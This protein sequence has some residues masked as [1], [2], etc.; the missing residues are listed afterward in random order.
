MARKGAKGNTRRIRK[1]AQSLDERRKAEM[2]RRES[3]QKIR[4]I[5]EGS[6]IPAFV[7]GT[8]HRIIYWN[9]ALEELSG[10]KA[11]DVIGTD[12]YWMAFYKEERP[13]MADLLVDK[14]LDELHDWYKDNYTKSKLIEEAYEAT[15]FFPDLGNKGK[16][17]RFTAAALKDSEGNLVGVIETLEDETERKLAQDALLESEQKLK[18][19]LEGSS[20]PAFV[21]GEDHR[22]LYW[23][24]ALEELSGTK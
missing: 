3:E 4:I 22:I 5:L 19:T 10:I 17:L 24:R 8:D 6:P 11:D 13:C 20:I 2:D 16:W 1:P 18:S 21:I 14:R 9:K 23:N 15:D 7:I 12:K